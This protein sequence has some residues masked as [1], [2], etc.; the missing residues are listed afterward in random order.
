MNS[1]LHLARIVLEADAALSIGA[2]TGGERDDVILI[3]DAMGLPTI[4]ASSLTGALRS[5]ATERY[6]D[7]FVKSVF[8]YL[9]PKGGQRSRL[10]VSW[11]ICHGEDDAPLECVPEERDGPRRRT[12]L[13]RRLMDLSAAPIKRDRVS[14]DHRATARPRGKFDRSLVP[15][16]VRFTVELRLWGAAGSDGEWQCLLG[17]L[18]GEGVRVGGATRAGLGR[19]SVER[20]RGKS[21]N[22]ADVRDAAEFRSLPVRCDNADT[23]PALAIK[24]VDDGSAHAV[25]CTI[26]LRPQG[27]LRVG[28]GDAPFLRDECSGNEASL[29]TQKSE[30]IVTWRNGR[31]QVER[32]GPLIPASSLKGAL[33]DRIA[34]HAHRHAGRF[35]ENATPMGWLDTGPSGSDAESLARYDKNLDVPEVQELFGTIGGR[36]GARAGRLILEDVWLSVPGE[37]NAAR[38]THNVIDRFT[39]GV[40]EHL[41]FTEEVLFQPEIEFRLLVRQPQAIGSGARHAL[42]DAIDDL[43]T[44]LLPL[45]AASTR[46]NGYF[47]G[48]ARWSDDGLWIQGETA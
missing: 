20:A 14:L 13:V 16:G 34:F 29:L 42:R 22:L 18:A 37:K 1:Y 43:V 39:G 35:V 3:E 48:E 9:G 46:G 38:V 6:G 21:F 19:L 30:T 27:F 4:P 44:G 15:K 32:S 7:E 40:R 41:L 26:K 45:G 2:R 10:T 17:L 8:G 31:G 11:G 33:S 12:A 23:L 47:F 28:Q 24:H 5:L 36:E 25:M